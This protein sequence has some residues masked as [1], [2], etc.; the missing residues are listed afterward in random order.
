MGVEGSIRDFLIRWLRRVFW[1]VL[2]YALG[3]AVVAGIFVGTAF[4]MGCLFALLCWR[5]PF[6]R[7]VNAEWGVLVSV[8]IGLVVIG[9]F[10]YMDSHNWHIGETLRKLCE[11]DKQEGFKK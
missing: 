1:Y 3:I 5:V 9:V 11:Y 7:G 2:T 6:L 10:I 4:L 8:G